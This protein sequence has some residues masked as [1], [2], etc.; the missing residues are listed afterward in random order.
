LGLVAGA[1]G[2]Q[3]GGGGNWGGFGVHGQ[4]SV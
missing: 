3:R 2:G 4:F 1:E